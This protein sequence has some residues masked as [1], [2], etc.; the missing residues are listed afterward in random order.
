MVVDMGI[1]RWMQIH[2]AVLA[3]V[4]LVTP[5]YSHPMYQDAPLDEDLIVRIT[6][7]RAGEPVSGRVAITGFAIDRRNPEH[8]GLNDRDIQIWL[9]DT[10]SAPSMLGYAS[11]SE[12]IVDIPPAL[13][14]RT[15]LLGFARVWD[16]CAAPPGRYE[17]TVWVSSLARPG[18]RNR[19]TTEVDVTPCV[20]TAPISSQA[21]LEGVPVPPPAMP[22]A[23]PTVSQLGAGQDP[24]PPPCSLGRLLPTDLALPVSGPNLSSPTAALVGVWEGHWT[25]TDRAAQLAVVSV[26]G[27]TAN[28]VYAWGAAPPGPNVPNPGPGRARTGGQVGND[29]VLTYQLPPVRYRFELQGDLNTLHGWWDREAL[30]SETTMRRC[31]LP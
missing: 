29:G 26:D 23:V 9:T 27:T 1:A 30:H 24:L 19:A 13:D 16:T 18:A 15:A 21:T 6:S 5:A 28:L 31:S 10:S 22:S 8:S 4:I 7:P 2:L 3:A 11:L 20:A 17:I 14:S 12:N 25:N